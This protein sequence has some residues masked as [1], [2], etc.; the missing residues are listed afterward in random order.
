M[1]LTS[2]FLSLFS[3]STF[4]TLISEYTFNGNANDSQ[5]AGNH[6]TVIGASL[7]SDR[8]GIVNS[9]YSFDGINDYIQIADSPSL[10]ITGDMTIEAWINTANTDAFQNMI[11]FSNMEE[12]SPHNGYML[13]V[14]WWPDDPTVKQIRFMSGDMSLWSNAAVNIGEWI[15]VAATLSGTSASIYL[16]GILDN[17]G[18]VGVPTSFSADQFIGQSTTPGNPAYHYDG[19]LDDIRIYNHALS[20]AEIQQHATFSVSEPVSLVM[21]GIDLFG[22][23]FNRRKRLH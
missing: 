23:G 5:S 13:S 1:F 18:I 12:I 20:Q 15:H 3:V 7:T 14:D 21:L 6:G 19:L 16:N 10:N 2:L 8:N 11:I 4:A 17:T 9:A 22:L